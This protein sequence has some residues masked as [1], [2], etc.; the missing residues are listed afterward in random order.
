MDRSSLL[1]AFNDHFEE[2]LDDVKAV[3]PDDEDIE[4]AQS[5]LKKLRKANPKLVIG[6]FR[7]SVVTPYRKAIEDGDLSFFVSK[8]YTLDVQGSGQEGFI[9]QKVEALRGP[10]SRLTPK[11]QGKVMEYIQNLTR[12]AD[13]HFNA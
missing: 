10:V 2:F 6:V 11:S 3:I 4:A 1:K 12:I 5:G 9:L 7:E 13:M 8:D